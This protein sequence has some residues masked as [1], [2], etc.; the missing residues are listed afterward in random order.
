[1]IE[2]TLLIFLILFIF[3][4]PFELFKLSYLAFTHL[5]ICKFSCNYNS[6]PKD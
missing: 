6:H 3:K 4:K 2:Y 1:M 5:A